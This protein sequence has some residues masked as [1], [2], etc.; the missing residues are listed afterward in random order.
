MDTN[1]SREV[2]SHGTPD[3]SLGLVE[4]VYDCGLD[5]TAGDGLI[6]CQ[7]SVDSSMG[8]PACCR[9]WGGR[10]ETLCDWLDLPKLVVLD[11]TRIRGCAL[12]RLPANTAGLLLDGIQNDGE[13]ARLETHFVSLWG[14]PVLGTLGRSP[15][16]RTALASLA[17]GALPSAEARAALAGELHSSLRLDALM[18]LASRSWNAPEPRLF[19][20]CQGAPSLN[21]AVA[22]DEVFGGYFQETLD[23][24][25]LRGARLEVFSPLRDEALPPDTDVVYF[26][27]G[28]P[29]RYA[30]ALAENSC[31]MLALREH[32]CSGRR[33]YGEGG[34]LAYL[35]QQIEL[36]DG[37]RYPM[38]GALPVVARFRPNAPAPEPV[39]LTFNRNL[40][41]GEGWSR[42]RG[43][44]SSRWELWPCG[45][46]SRYAAEPR[47][48]LDFVGRHHA[49][50]SRVHI[51]FAAQLD[52]LESFFQPHAP[53]LD[54][55]AL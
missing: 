8:W 11:V 32:L 53:A 4:G 6:P 36:A 2:F 41:L 7:A 28:F 51:N 44:L 48:D 3:G 45:P 5:E 42:I 16:L 12:P 15:R 34:G 20:A 50:G 10:L 31:L 49:I 13:A 46:L 33:M 35:C 9:G 39:E 40:W 54:A 21:I 17:P 38:V 24:L 27:C 55:A 14:L 23:V 26:G 37:S 29:E 52:Y 1:T 25:E 30:A 22:H 47:H 43:Y 18:R 19:G